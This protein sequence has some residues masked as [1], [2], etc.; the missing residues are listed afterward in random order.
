[1]RSAAV[2]GDE[3]EPF[4][5]LGLQR[6]QLCDKGLA[7]AAGELVSLDRFEDEDASRRRRGRLSS[8]ESRSA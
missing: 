1:M 3:A 6:R 5:D 7:V 8:S 2:L 4:S